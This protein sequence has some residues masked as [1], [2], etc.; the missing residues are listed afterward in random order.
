MLANEYVVELVDERKTSRG[1]NRNQHS[2]SAIRIATLS[3]EC[4]WEPVVMNP[5]EGELRELQRRSRI[6]SQGRVTISSEMARRV[7]LGELTL[8]E[9][10]EQF[11]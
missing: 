4:V 8:I 2:V 10:I 11:I 3:G 1:L 9:A 6:K 7:A 5:T